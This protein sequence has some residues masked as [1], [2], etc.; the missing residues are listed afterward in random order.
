MR[1]LGTMLTATLRPSSLLPE[2]GESCVFICFVSFL[3]VP[4]RFYLFRCVF[5]C[6]VSFSH[7]S[8][9]NVQVKTNGL[10]PYLQTDCGEGNSLNRGS[11][12]GL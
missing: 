5:I 9:H 7:V 2:D 3:S 12:K 1:L 8:L 4:L 11:G 10:L 6:F